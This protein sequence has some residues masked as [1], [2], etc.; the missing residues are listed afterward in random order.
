MSAKPKKYIFVNGVMKLNPEYEA[1][2]GTPATANTPKPAETLAV[3]SSMNDIVDATEAQADATGAPMQ[4]SPSTSHAM[5]YMQ[6]DEY[7]TQFQS[8]AEMDGGEVLD[9]LTEY[10]VQYEIPIG[11]INKLRALSYYRLNFIIDDSGSMRAQ[12]DV[13]LTE[14]TPYLLRG[15]VPAEGARMT[16]WQEAENR[17]HIMLDILAFIPTKQIVISFLNARNV[18]SLSREGRSIEAFKSEAHTSISSA[19][20]SIDVKYKT[21]TYRVLSEAF[22]AAATFPDPT[23]HYLLTDG[24]PSDQPPAAVA[25]LIMNRASP[26]RNPLTLMSCTNEDSEVEWMKQ[27]RCEML[28]WHAVRDVVLI[29]LLTHAPFVHAM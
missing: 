6:G 15:Q 18:I 28:T 19:F 29:G 12:T 4:L 16:R 1:A 13:F 24:V 23:S 2:N 8:G 17:M 20:A 10:F 14:A 7:L 11:L 25:Q 5:Q 21:P 3:V 9:G 22:A 26:N 27:V